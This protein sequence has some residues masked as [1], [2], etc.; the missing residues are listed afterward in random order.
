MTARA[1]KIS[2]LGLPPTSSATPAKPT[3]N[4]MSRE[5]RTRSPGLKRSASSAAKS[6]A[7]AWM[8]AVKLESIRVSAQVIARIGIAEL[9]RPV[10]TSGRGAEFAGGAPYSH[11]EQHDRRKRQRAEPHPEGDERDRVELAIPDLDEHERG[12]PQRR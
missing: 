5:P 8:I 7:E 9:S 12:A 4:P 11:G 3:T 6:G 10:T 2:P 1:A